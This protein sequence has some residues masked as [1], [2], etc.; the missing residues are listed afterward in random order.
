MSNKMKPGITVDEEVWESFKEKTKGESSQK[1]EQFMEEYQP[2]KSASKIQP[3]I[4]V[5]EEVWKKFKAKFLNEASKVVE[6]LM[7]AKLQDLDVLAVPSAS[8]NCLTL[9]TNDSTSWTMTYNDNTI[10]VT[11]NTT[12]IGM[13]FTNSSAAAN[14]GFIATASADTNI[15][16]FTNKGGQ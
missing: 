1:V 14:S 10:N 5:D 6:A 15:L 3:G 8:I 16:I 7:K 13:S 11:P 4:T 12:N 2:P 9:P